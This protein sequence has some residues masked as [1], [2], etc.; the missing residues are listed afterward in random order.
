MSDIEQIK[1][2]WRLTKIE[3]SIS[4]IQEVPR[5]IIF[6]FIIESGPLGPTWLMHLFEERKNSRKI[7]FLIF[8]HIIMHFFGRT[9]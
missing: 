1:L 7:Y 9:L 6:L 4:T 8:F 5:D 3:I 2:I